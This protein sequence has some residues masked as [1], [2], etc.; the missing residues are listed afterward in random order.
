[1][2]INNIKMLYGNRAVFVNKTAAI[3]DDNLLIYSNGKINLD[4]YLLHDSI[5]YEDI[6]ILGGEQTVFINTTTGDIIKTRYDSIYRAGGIIV[7]RNTENNIEVYNNELKLIDTIKLKTSRFKLTSEIEATK[8]AF[9]VLCGEKLED[10]RLFRV[11]DDKC[12]ED[13]GTAIEKLRMV[14]QEVIE[15]KNLENVYKLVTDTDSWLIYNDTVI[16]INEYSIKSKLD[17]KTAVILENEGDIS[18]NYDNRFDGDAVEVRN[19]IVDM[20]SNRRIYTTDEKHSICDKSKHIII[21]EGNKL[22]L[23]DYRL[24]VIM[25]WDNIEWHNIESDTTNEKIIQ[26]KISIEGKIK[27]LIIYLDKKVSEMI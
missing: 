24:N 5:S 19:I 12:E 15:I 6:I 20:K 13:S 2:K 9:I 3:I 23:L 17:N 14:Q 11:I 25:N 4:N 18:Y 10:I 27:K 1:M 8:D 22:L 21:Q 16:N 26:V 7:I